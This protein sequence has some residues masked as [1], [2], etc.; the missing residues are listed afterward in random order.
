MS[1]KERGKGFLTSD[2]TQFDA[3]QLQNIFNDLIWTRVDAV[4]L[5]IANQDRI[6]SVMGPGTQINYGSRLLIMWCSIY[7]CAGALEDNV[8]TLMT[9]FRFSLIK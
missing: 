8:K 1:T 7:I 4:G 9:F 6:K 3:K 2:Y 5:E